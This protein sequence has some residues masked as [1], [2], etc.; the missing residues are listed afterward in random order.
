MQKTNLGLTEL[1]TQIDRM[2]VF[3]KNEYY[4][5][6]NIIKNDYEACSLVSC[7]KLDYSNN[8]AM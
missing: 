5:I 4:L 8:T 6:Q 2:G 7:L 3:I 1:L